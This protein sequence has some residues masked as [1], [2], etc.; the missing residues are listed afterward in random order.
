MAVEKCRKC[1]RAALIKGDREIL[2]MLLFTLRKGPSPNYRLIC[3]FIGLSVQHLLRD[4]LILNV[5]HNNPRPRE[6]V[7]ARFALKRETG[8]DGF[9]RQW[10][11]A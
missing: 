5:A 6:P 3:I 8:T 1:F 2:F 4:W 10:S 11:L 7:G 9:T